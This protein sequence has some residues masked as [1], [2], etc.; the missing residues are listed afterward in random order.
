[1]SLIR[2]EDSETKDSDIGTITNCFPLLP[3]FAP[4]TDRPLDPHNDLLPPAYAYPLSNMMSGPPE[5]IRERYFSLSVSDIEQFQ[6]EKIKKWIKVYEKVLGMCFRRIREYVLH[7]ERYC[8]FSIPEYLPGFPMFNMTHCAAFI[9]RKLR[10]A[11]FR[12]QLVPPN[13]I[14]IFWDTDRDYE[15]AK[16]SPKQQKY[17]NK[18]PTNS[19]NHTVESDVHYITLLPSADNEQTNIVSPP[20]YTNRSSKMYGSQKEEPFLFN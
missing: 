8:F 20:K 15:Q 18:Q 2:W 10:A 14:A 3:R 17:I 7:D 5:I 6:K 11:R 16:P 13:I 12:T 19:N 4:P 1:M 9:I